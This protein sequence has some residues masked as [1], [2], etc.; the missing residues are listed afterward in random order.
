MR[1][2]AGR[3]SGA[4]CNQEHRKD[5]DRH[6]MTAA[7]EPHGKVVVR[8]LTEPMLEAERLFAYRSMGST[9][10]SISLQWSQRRRGRACSGSSWSLC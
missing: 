4:A 7:P 6:P 5:Y 3:V 10:T 8:Q 1:R 2:E 9:T